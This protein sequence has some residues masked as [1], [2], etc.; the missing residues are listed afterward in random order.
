MIMEAEFS[1][2]QISVREKTWRTSQKG[3]K[4]SPGIKKGEEALTSEIAEYTSIPALRKSLIM[5][6][7]DEE[8]CELN[9]L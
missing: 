7:L 4:Y 8:T 6:A 3:W 2:G 1:P 5:Q 9:W